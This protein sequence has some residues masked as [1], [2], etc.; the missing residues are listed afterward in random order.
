MTKHE[1]WLTGMKREWYK[2]AYWVKSCL[3][4][5]RTDE[6]EHYLVRADANGYYY[7]N[8]DTG[9]KEYIDDG[10]D[11]S[12]PL[13]DFKE[14]ITVPNGFIFPD[15]GEIKTSVGNLLQN[16]LL[17]IDPFKGKVPYI[18][19]RF[20]PS[21]VE[22]LIIRKWK[23]SRD[24][25]K[26]DLVEGEIFTEE[27][28]QYAENAIYLSNFTQT[29][30]PSITKK[31]IISNPAVE[32]RKKELFTEY[33]DKLDDPIVQTMIDDELKKI[34]KDYLKDDDFMGFAISGKVF[35][36]A[37]KRLTYH[38][39]FAKG[40]DDTKEPTYINRPLNKGVD[41]KNLSTYVNDA[42][43]GSIGRGLETQEG[44]V[45]VKNAVRS[46]ANLKVDGK[47]CGT[48]YGE[49]ILFDEDSKKNEKYLDYYFIQNGVTI[50]ITEENI[51][52][53]AGKEVMMRSPRMCVSKNN[54]YC[55]HC[56]GPNISSYPNGI[57]SVNALPGSKI[58]LISMKGMHTS[59]KDS[60]KLDWQNLIT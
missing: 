57:A 36:D 53:L 8:E 45:D 14:L 7:L 15:W 48:K 27:Y 37:R 11:T 30:V 28:L 17:V 58:M 41:P 47:E 59:A 60:I 38:F 33:K 5:F 29:V 3:S 18:N 40:L 12:K 21:D 49:P 56:A 23:R 43:S 6:K 35:N 44:G 46:A 4:I 34:D 50:K 9:T 39:G 52:S 20:F 10:Q 55:E 26:N 22:K 24:E 31:A 13:L 16:Y 25:V 32:K 2:D 1:F 51:A 42:Y 54:S 19:K